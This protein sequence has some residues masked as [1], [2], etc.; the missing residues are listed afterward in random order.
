MGYLAAIAAFAVKNYLFYT[1]NLQLKPLLLSYYKVVQP[2][3]EHDEPLI[4]EGS[5][6]EEYTF[7]RACV[8]LF[9]IPLENVEPLRSLCINF[10]K[11]P[12]SRENLIN[13]FYND[14][15][16]M[17]EHMGFPPFWRNHKILK[18]PRSEQ[19]EMNRED[20]SRE[21]KQKYRSNTFAR[22]AARRADGTLKPKPQMYGSR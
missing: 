7:T 16:W 11:S 1:P 15:S 13:V 8:E 21:R 20:W 4:F 3:V 18:E 2:W 19:E 6:D 12:E 22:T 5:E 9:Q 14:C 10:R 17:P